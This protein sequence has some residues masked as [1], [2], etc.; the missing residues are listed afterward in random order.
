MKERAVFG[1]LSFIYNIHYIY[2]TNNLAQGDFD[3]NFDKNIGVLSP[4]AE[5]LNNIK[6]GVKVATDKEKSLRFL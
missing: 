6:L 2:A 5:I 1:W 4:M 3:T